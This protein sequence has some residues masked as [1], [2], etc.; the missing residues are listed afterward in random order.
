M[1]GG[2]NIFYVT[3]AAV[4][5][6]YSPLVPVVQLAGVIMAPDGSPVATA[7]NPGPNPGYEVSIPFTYGMSLGDI[8]A[9]VP[10]LLASGWGYTEPVEVV[11]LPL[12]F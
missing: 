1:P 5:Y 7:D 9:A 3:V 2:T 6:A 11:V 4:S 8:I 10:A 12:I